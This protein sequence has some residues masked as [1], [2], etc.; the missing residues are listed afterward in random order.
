LTH[1]YS[2]SGIEPRPIVPQV[3]CKATGE[4]VDFLFIPFDGRQ[5]LPDD[6]RD[7]KNIDPHRGGGSI[8]KSEINSAVKS[9]MNSAMKCR[10]VCLL[11]AGCLALSG[12][13]AVVAHHS[14]AAAYN[15]EA[16]ISIVGKV[17]E[18]RL[19]NPHS[20]FFLD[21]TGEDGT[22]TSWKFEAGTPSGMLRNGYSPQVIK[23]GDTVTIKGFRA[24]NE[25]N[26]GMLRELI[27]ADGTVYGMF[28]P[29]QN[30][31]N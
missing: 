1:D 17:V 10:R 13:P 23:K 31:G 2:S 25:S 6:Q 7:K 8:M 14:F 15:M 16:P 27:T 4:F 20:H 28:G 30:A 5:A 9:V 11:I 24:R 3:I 12:S 18:V 21:V 26:N 29:Q 19:T 22:T